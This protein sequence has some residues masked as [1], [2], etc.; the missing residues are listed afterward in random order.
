MTAF[1]D[2]FGALLVGQIVTTFL[3]GLSTLQTYTY[4]NKYP[5]DGK[6]LK[7]WVGAIWAIDT[8]NVALGG[9]VTDS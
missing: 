9:P 8:A 2:G 1:D 4:Y 5:R 3:Y 6:E 7:I